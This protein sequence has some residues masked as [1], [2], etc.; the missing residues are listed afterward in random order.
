M[1]KTSVR[2]VLSVISEGLRG[3]QTDFTSGS[4]SKAVLLLS[5]PMILEMALES[6][7]TVVDAFFIGRLGSDALA[8]LGVTD[9]VITLIFAAAIGISMGT[10]AMVAR[11]IGEKDFESASKTAAQ[12]IWLGVFI[13]LPIAILGVLFPQEILGLMGASEQVVETGWGGIRQYCLEE[14]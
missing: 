5:V 9:A 7:F 13:A 2:S 12:S 10:T 4:I 8:A 6:V 14:I 3:N 1:K 11:R